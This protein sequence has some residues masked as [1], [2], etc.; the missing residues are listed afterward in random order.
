MLLEEEFLAE[1]VEE[2]MGAVLIP[3]AFSPRGRGPLPE[4][5]TPEAQEEANV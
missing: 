3:Q 5:K 1:L 2:C 4:R